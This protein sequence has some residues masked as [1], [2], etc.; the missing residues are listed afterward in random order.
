MEYVDYSDIPNE[1]IDRLER[2]YDYVYR[3]QAYEHLDDSDKSDFVIDCWIE[4][5]NTKI[6]RSVETEM[7]ADR[8]KREYEQKKWEERKRKEKLYTRFWKEFKVP[9]DKI[10]GYLRTVGLPF[11]KESVEQFK[12]EK[13]SID[14]VNSRR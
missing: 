4:E 7:E 2:L 5:Q 1:D 11:D 13:K 8:R 6:K 12:R 10:K 3:S 14:G 9:D